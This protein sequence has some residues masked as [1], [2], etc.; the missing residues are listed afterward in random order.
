MRDHPGTMGVIAHEFGHD[1]KWPDL[2]DIDGS[3]Y[4]VG[5]WAL[6]GTG[7]WNGLGVAGDS[8][9]LPDVWSKW[10]QGWLTPTTI[11]GY[12][13]G[14]PIPQIETNPT[15]FLLRP[16]PD[17][18]DWLYGANSGQGEYFLVENRQQTSYD[19]ALPG[20]GLLIWHIDET[21]RSD[22]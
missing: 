8:P 19:L 1:L 12:S 17:A 10:Y 3:S 4:G 18:V 21:L 15:A 14:Q 9:A 11:S 2:Y 20:E 13:Y 16:N 6:M 22:N 7:Y 5:D